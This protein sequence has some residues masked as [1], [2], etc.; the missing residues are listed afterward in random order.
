MADEAA[1]A[2]PK[3]AVFPL[4]GAVDEEYRSKV[5]FSLRA[6]LDRG[7]TYEIIDGPRMAEIAAEAGG[8]I[9]LQT[10][11]KTLRELVKGDE[12]AVLI[13]G[14]VSAQGQDKLVHVKVLDL[15]AGE[16]PKEIRKVIQ[17]PTDLR[18]VAEDILAAIPGVAFEHPSEVAVQKDPKAEGLWAKNPNLVV[19]GDFAKSANWQ[20]IYQAELYVPESSAEPPKPD[21]VVI[22]NGALVMNLSRTCA[23]NNGMACLSDEIKIEPNTRYRL[24]FRYKSDGPKLH[25]FIKGYT[26]GPDINGQKTWREIYRR[27]VPP[28]AGTDGKWVTIV[29]EMNPQHHVFP[30]KILKIDLYAYLHLGIVEF[31]D[32]VLKAVGEQTHKAKD[33]A[34]DQPVTRPAGRK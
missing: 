16:G 8:P 5:G 18:F 9:G 3:V 23:E 28:T 11:V 15:R 6:K 27:Q 31:D 13:W 25:V 21:K 1:K 33:E 34:L 17:A 32:V 2:K 12:P 4:S 24:S 30:V 22:H 10:P 26:E 20:A 14:E 29:D 7:G 19:N